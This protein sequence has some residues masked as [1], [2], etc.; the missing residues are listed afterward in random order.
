M[1]R[2]LYSRGQE[3]LALAEAMAWIGPGSS[4]D[5]ISQCSRNLFADP[6]LC[7]LHNLSAQPGTR[8]SGFLCFVSLAS[9]EIAEPAA[10]P[11]R[12]AVPIISISG[13]SSTRRKLVGSK[14]GES[15][16]H[17]ITPRGETGPGPACS[18]SEL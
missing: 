11:P 14:P 3:L 5:S 10:R 13:L 15:E 7:R 8:A 12:V 1:P 4:P 17:E 16:C 6:E 2:M 9:P 18:G